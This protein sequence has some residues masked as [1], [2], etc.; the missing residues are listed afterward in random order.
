MSGD[1][2]LTEKTLAS[3]NTSVF[4]LFLPSSMALALFQDFGS[5]HISV[6]IQPKRCFALVAIVN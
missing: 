5:L 2:Q 6:I 1:L 3:R 4:S